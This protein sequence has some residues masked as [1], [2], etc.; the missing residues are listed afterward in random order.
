M[1]TEFVT[2]H[3]SQA[4]L[5]DQCDRERSRRLMAAL[6][7]I[8][9]QWGV[10]TVRYAAVGLRPRWIMRCGH[11]SPRYTT[12]WDGDVSPSFRA[13]PACCTISPAALRWAS[14]I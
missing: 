5:F 13:M 2:A 11:R 4:H 1:L 7:T 8:N 9:T 6:D 3:Q 14:S 10:G 12:R